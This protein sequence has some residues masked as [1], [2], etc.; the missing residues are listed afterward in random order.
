MKLASNGQKSMIY[1]PV[2]SNLKFPGS[3]GK[4]S[5]PFPEGT[6]CIEYSSIIQLKY[7]EASSTTKLHLG[8]LTLFPYFGSKQPEIFCHFI[9]ARSRQPSIE[10]FS[11]LFQLL[12]LSEAIV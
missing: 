5:P 9:G 2:Y 6:S 11:N 7:R 4:E 8:F 1:Q 3:F 12:A 10:S